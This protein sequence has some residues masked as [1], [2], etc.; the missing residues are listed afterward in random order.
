MSY[1]AAD[2]VARGAVFMLRIRSLDLHA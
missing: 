2:L 1:V